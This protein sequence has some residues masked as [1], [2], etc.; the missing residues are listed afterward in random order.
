M[1]DVSVDRNPAQTQ[2]SFGMVVH[3]GSVTGSDVRIEGPDIGNDSGIFVADAAATIR[4]TTVRARTGISV[5]HGAGG[6]I[7]FRADAE[8]FRLVVG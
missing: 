6:T 8:S 1:T 2:P 4:D 5:L 7:D 3:G